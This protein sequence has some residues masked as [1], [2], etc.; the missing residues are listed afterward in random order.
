M[1]LQTQNLV[2]IGLGVQ[3]DC[4]PTIPCR[5]QPKLVDGIHLRWA[6]TRERGFPWYGYY[7][8][9]RR[10]LEGKPLC[11]SQVMSNLPVGSWPRTTVSSPGF[12]QISSNSNLLLTDDFP[13]AGSVEFDLEGRQSLRFAAPA[14]EPVRRVEVRIGFRSDATIRVTALLQNDR[15]EAPVVQST[16]R[17]RAGDIKTASLEFDAITAVEIGPGP[18]ALI[19]LCVVPVASDARQGWELVPDFPYPL[20][21][22]VSHP[23]YPCHPQPEDIQTARVQA[24]DR[25]WYGNPMDFVPSSS[26]VYDV[27]TVDVENGSP[28]VRGNGTHWTDAVLGASLQVNGDPTAY[29]I[30]QVIGP[31]KLV[32]SR[33]YGGVTRSGVAYMMH[34][35][36]FEQL[37]D[38]LVHLVAGGVTAGPMVHR[39]FPTPIYT[40]GTI[41]L[42]N[43]SPTVTGFGTNWSSELTGL[44][45]QVVGATSG[46]SPVMNTISVT[47]GKDIVTGSGTHWTTALTGMVLRVA[48]ERETYTV[49]QV[50]PPTQLTLQQSYT[51]SSGGGRAYTITETTTYTVL[52]VDSPTQLTLNQPYAGI[53]GTNKAYII[54][55]LL[56]PSASKGKSPRMPKQYPLDLVLLGALHPAVAQMIGLYWADQ[57]VEPDHAYDYLILA[58]HDGRFGCNV[59]NVLR[60]LQENVFPDVDGYIV[61]NKRR[62]PAPPLA[63]PRDVRVYALPGSAIR[64]EDGSIQ[65]ASNNAGLC[66]DRGVKSMGTQR[67]LLPDRPV[68]YHLWRTQGSKSEP[69][70]PPAPTDYHLLT[71]RQPILVTEPRLPLGQKPQRPPDWPS[72]PLHTIDAGLEEGWYSYQ[73]SGVDIFGRHSPNSDAATWCQ[74]TPDDAVVHPFA[75]HLLDK[76]PPPPP[77]GIEAYAL[78]PA[79]PAVIKDDAYNAWWTAL[80]ASAWYQALSEPEKKKLIGLRVRWQWTEAHMRQAPDA[81]EFRIYYHPDRL[82]ALLGRTVTVSPV[83]S[84]DTE[85]TTDIPNTH[86][87]NKFAEAWLRIG[88]DSFKIVSSDVANPL[89]VCVKN[90]GP[91]DKGA[92]NVIKD[93]ARV[94]GNQTYWH[95]GLAG[96]SLQVLGEPTV[97]KILAVKSPTELMLD[98]RYTGATGNKAY[99]IFDLRPRANAPC[100]IV[101]PP[102]YGKGPNPPPHPLFVDYTHAEK[103]DE[104]LYV[105]GYNEHITESFVPARSSD[106][107]PLKGAGATSAGAVISLDGTPDLSEIH[108]TGEHLLLS[109]DT[110]RPN[111]L[112][113]IR[114]FDNIARTVTVDGTPTLVG[115]ASPWTIGRRLRT[116]EIFL[117]NPSEALHNGL[118]LKSPSFADPIVYAH[119]GVSAADD[120]PHTADDPT[121][122]WATGHWGGRFGNEGP[123]GPP[124]TVFRVQREAPKPP[125]PPPDSDKVF[126]TPADYHGHSYY[127]YRWKKPEKGLKAHVLRAL[128]DAIFKCDWLIRTTRTALD[129]T[130]P[131]HQ[132]VFPDKD[133][134]GNLWDVA[135]KQAAANQLNAI[136]SLAQYAGLSSDARVILQRLPGNEGRQWNHGL[137][138][139]DWEIRQT[140]KNLTANDTKYFPDDWNKPD[141]NPA[142]P[143]NQLRRDSV[144]QKLNAIMGVLS[145]KAATTTNTLVTL[146]GSPDLTLVRPYRDTLWLA[147]DKAR[148][149]GLYRIT[150]VDNT[151]HTVTLE[152]TPN[153]STSTSAWA[154]YL[155]EYNTSVKDP[156]VLTNDAMRILAGLPGNERVFTQLTIQP[157]DPADPDN[158]NKRGPDDPDTFVLGDPAN[159]L[160]DTSLCIY[161]DTLDGRSTN[162]YFYRSAYVDGANNRSALSLSSPPVWLPKVMPPRAP[163]FTRI[164]AGD[165]DPSKAGD[166]KITLYWA[167]NR[168]EDLVEY[169]VYRTADPSRSRDIRMMDLVQTIPIPA[170]STLQTE[171]YWV[172]DTVQGLVTYSYRL[173]VMDN[174]GNSSAPSAII[175]ARAFDTASPEPPVVTAQWLERDGRT[176]AEI[177]WTSSHEVLLQRR[178]PGGIWIDLTQWHSPG[179]VLVRDPF[180][181]PGQSYEYRVRVRK[182]TGATVFSPSVTLAAQNN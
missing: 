40:A 17:G 135:R 46:T 19:E 35:D 107:E 138:E 39:S 120:K 21:L 124:V 150:A 159:P 3:D 18:A 182:H 157:L 47:N 149:D 38:A 153:L 168:E 116:Y 89:R 74:G 131:R 51:G 109:N 34:H 161:V 86:P 55:S 136:Q 115:G 102:T 5:V 2:M 37:H 154:L 129:P 79:D 80:T 97:Y 117:P 152:D 36:A 166:C 76:I 137:Q 142:N 60:L 122:K 160:A 85:V 29:T 105:V 10:H 12:G 20:S 70:T 101:I 112:Y 58:D 59:N 31:E 132:S 134:D 147:G 90:L 42:E 8:F 151:S 52:R 56:Q 133:H 16:V 145:G 111:G 164:L 98:R 140:R 162:R 103:W 11:L 33:N 45:L 15:Y 71:G 14:G 73:V 82:N 23:D 181:E 114:D 93:S 87:T 158:A 108:L 130:L 67:V 30:I 28:V 44:A 48:E 50:N 66:W 83:S 170:S 77:T 118:P 172:D 65:D 7:L 127:T 1:A 123:V 176:W 68:L 96:S 141:P 113:E 84:T 174:V 156:A 64:K 27:G 78:D 63:A 9:R 92:L 180:S 4:P 62:A 22:P 6:F 41:K 178:E 54:T 95:A 43:K 146:D 106:G 49:S 125:E 104:R 148:K 175:T 143:T 144:A 177:E 81:H 25:I 163:V 179:H 94:T 173:V 75:V 69:P 155:D 91:Y 121:A 110:A 24:G 171:V 57:T 100:T 61:F 72:F 53:T 99:I 126:A 26:P 32:V 165:P 119:I 139:R 13:P 128:D 169:R 167:S 88:S